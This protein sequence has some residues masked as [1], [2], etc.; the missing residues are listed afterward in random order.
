MTDEQI[1]QR[2]AK[3]TKWKSKT[4]GPSWYEYETKMPNWAGCLNAMH[5]AENNLDFDQ[6]HK[7]A[8]LIGRHDYKLL[9][10]ANARQKAEAFLK[11]LGKW[12]DEA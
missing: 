7:Y 8:S 12:E 9:V 10:N 5:E 6:W 4:I 3:A 1:N 11:T 2:I